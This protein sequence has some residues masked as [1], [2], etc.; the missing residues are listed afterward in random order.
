MPERRI[1]FSRKIREDEI[2]LGWSVGRSFRMEIFDIFEDTTT[3]L[4]SLQII[5]ESKDI[6]I[7]KSAEVIGE[8]EPDKLW[9]AKSGKPVYIDNIF[10]LQRYHRQR[11]QVKPSSISKVI[12]N[13]KPHEGLNFFYAVPLALGI[14]ML[15]QEYEENNLLDY[16][17]FVPC[18]R[19]DRRKL[20]GI[21]KKEFPKEL[22][23]TPLLRKKVCL[24]ECL[25]LLVN[26]FTGVPVVRGAI[27]KLDAGRLEE[28][29]RYNWE[30][31]HDWEYDYDRRYELAC[32]WYRKGSTLEIEHFI[33]RGMEKDMYIHSFE[34]KPLESEELEGCNIAI[35][36]DFI[37]SGST[38]NRCAEIL[39]T[40][41]KVGKV[42]VFAGGIRE[43][44]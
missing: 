41:F 13:M 18:K 10:V 33:R 32:Q 22:S 39:K 8:Y 28:R 2:K 20:Y 40:K 42:H 9:V 30:Y 15:V 23:K 26:I 17:T 1:K 37:V 21:D 16:L 27:K 24:G 36:D 11:D 35:I 3:I 43:I 44:S 38:V 4:G 31:Y 12:W 5:N 14:A 29:Y 19:E 7:C 25:A 6:E 34:R